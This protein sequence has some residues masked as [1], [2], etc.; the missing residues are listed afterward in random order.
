[1]IR[2]TP[3][4]M[5]TLESLASSAVRTANKAKAKLIIVLL[6]FVFLAFPSKF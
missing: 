4:P 3:L 1:M 6:F 5:S 2:A